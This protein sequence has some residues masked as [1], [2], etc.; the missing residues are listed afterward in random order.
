MNDDF[1]SI[2]R[3]VELGL[4]L[5]IANQMVSSMNQSLNQMQVPNG[6]VMRPKAGE[7]YYVV[8]DGKQAGPYLLTEL[9]RLIEEKRVCKET[10]VWKPGMTQWDLAENI[11]ELVKLVALTP[12]PVPETII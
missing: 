8:I 7:Y 9:Y 2:D 6:Q 11:A 1:N 10:Y 12:P 3:L 4:S 5:A